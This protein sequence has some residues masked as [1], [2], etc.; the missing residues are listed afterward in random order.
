M[1]VY[2]TTPLQVY[3]LTE[4]WGF[5]TGTTGLSGTRTYLETTTDLSGVSRVDL[6]KLGDSWDEENYNIT[7]KDIAVALVNNSEQCGRKHICSYDG[8]PFTQVAVPLSDDDVPR[9]VEVGGEYLTW[10][11]GGA[12]SFYFPSDSSKVQ[13]AMAY[14]V[15]LANFRMYRVISNSYIDNY[16]VTVMDIVNL[17]NDATFVG[18]ATEMVMFTGANMTE[19]KNRAGSTRWR[20]ELCF[21]VRQ[22]TDKFPSVKQP[23]AADGWNYILRQDTGKF[24]RP[25]IGGGPASIYKTANFKSLFN[26]HALG[27]DENLYQIIPD[28]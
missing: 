12:G 7:L 25:I 27:S 28:K 26:A 14:Q 17:L 3:L 4:N 19:F 5:Q 1:S 21:S 2:T 22:V 24:E 15:S 23:A 9:S 18:F 8:V 10:V 20:V 13:Q 6:P 11:E 16:M